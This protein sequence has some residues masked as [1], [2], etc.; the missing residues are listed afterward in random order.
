VNEQH[1]DHAACGLLTTNEHGTVL[2]VNQ[3]LLNWIGAQRSEIVGCRTF[4]DLLTAGGRIY[5]ETHYAPMLAMQGTAREIAFDLALPDGHR[6]PV[7]VNARSEP[8][9][10][11]RVIHVAVFDATERRMYERELLA[12]K[13]H[14]ERSEA[15]TQLLART[16]QD[17]LLPNRLPT[18]PG[19]AVA[20]VYL[21]AGAGHEIGGDFYDVF[22]IGRAG[23]R[24]RTTQHPCG[25]GGTRTRRRP[26]N[27]Q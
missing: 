22:Q 4:A 13:E 1:F 26:S 23:D 14:A 2:A 6:L 19:L 20:G 25:V 16:L 7:L 11:G 17:S 21:P 8:V 18:I 5:H 27:R 9:D 24:P 12:A 3:T 10:D 15:H